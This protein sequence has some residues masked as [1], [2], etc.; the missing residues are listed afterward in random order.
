MNSKFKINFSYYT[1]I[2]Q[3]GRENQRHPAEDCAKN[4]WKILCGANENFGNLVLVTALLETARL[5]F[6]GFSAHISFIRNCSFIFQTYVFVHVSINIFCII[7][8]IFDNFWMKYIKCRNSSFIY[9]PMSVLLW[10]ARLFIF[11]IF[12]HDPFD[13]DCSII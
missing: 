8:T 6:L 12:A 3:V 7:D 4:W 1:Y 5:F 13:R 10:T 2:Y 11:E 9:L